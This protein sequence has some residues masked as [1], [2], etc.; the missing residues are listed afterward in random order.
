[1]TPEFVDTNVFLYA[2]DPSAAD[3][4]DAAKGLVGRLGRVRAGVISVQ[5]LQEF[6]VNVTRKIAVPATPAQARDRLAVLARWRV[7]SPRAGDVIAATAI[8]EEATL[9]FW[10]AMIIRSAAQMHCPV[11]WTDDLNHGQIIGGVQIRNPFA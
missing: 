11:L 2:Y 8:A 7:H 10:D 3:R 5:V 6:Y 4:H 9:S 1:M